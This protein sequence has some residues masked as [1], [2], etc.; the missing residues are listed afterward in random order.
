MGRPRYSRE[1]LLEETAMTVM[2]RQRP[3]LRRL[4]RSL[5]VKSIFLTLILALLKLRIPPQL[6][7]TSWT[8]GWEAATL[9]P[10]PTTFS[11]SWT[12]ACHKHSQLLKQ[13]F[14]SPSTTYSAAS[15]KALLPSNNSRKYQ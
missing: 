3:S 9:Q 10:L 13:I 1:Y 14:N 11:T 8:L 4:A 12:P 2:M 15:G 6:R 7:T 5:L